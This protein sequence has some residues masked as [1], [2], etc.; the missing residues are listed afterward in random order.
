MDVQVQ[1]WRPE[2]AVT[3]RLGGRTSHRVGTVE[4]QRFPIETGVTG[5]KLSFSRDTVSDGFFSP[6]H[7]HCWD[8]LR[9]VLDGT[10]SIGKADLESGDCGYFPEAVAYGPQEQAGDATVLVLQFTGAGGLYYP[11]WGE[12][13]AAG[14]KLRASG[15]I[16]EGGRYKG[17]TPDGGRIDQDGYEAMW[18]AAQGRKLVYAQPRYS[19]VVIMKSSHYEWLPD[20]GHPGVEVKALGSFT[21]YQTTVA[22]VRLTAGSRLDG[23]NLSAPQLRYV[24]SGAVE[25]GGQVYPAGSCFWVPGGALSLPLDS[26]TGA[27]LYAVTIP[28]YAGK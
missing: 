14:E 19:D 10:L 21:E 25:R 23:E 20:P 15:G 13:E 7:R 22:L 3:S 27:E 26:T 9:F 16:F 12:L 4:Q 17:S 8:Q 28:R 6:R 5:Y 1:A 11:T 2:D 24:L 18:E